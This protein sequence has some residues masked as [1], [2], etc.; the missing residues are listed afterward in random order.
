MKILYYTCL[1]L[2]IT[3]A[4]ACKTNKDSITLDDIEEEKPQLTQNEALATKIIVNLK[5]EYSPQDLEAEFTK[6][7]LTSKT[8]TN[9]T[10]N[11]WLFTFNGESIKRK[12]LLNLLNKHEFVVKAKG[13]GGQKI[14]TELSK[15][16]HKK[17]VKIATQ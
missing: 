4:T 1:I 7:E 9:K 10:L 11:A 3:L 15:S 6:Y 14:G 5:P 12:R 13:L 16:T 2:C 8:K 17:K